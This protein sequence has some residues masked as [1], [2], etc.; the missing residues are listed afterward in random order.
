M[1][2]KNGN[3]RHV[4]ATALLFV[5]L[6]VGS[7]G[8][9]GCIPAVVIPGVVI[10]QWADELAD[11]LTQDIISSSSLYE[12]AVL[13]AQASDEAVAALGYPLVGGRVGTPS[14]YNF[15]APGYGHANISFRISGPKGTGRLHLVA[16]LRGGAAETW[17]RS[18]S[19]AVVVTIPDYRAAD[20]E[21][22]KLELT[23]DNSA[24]WIDLL[25]GAK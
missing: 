5:V 14:E 7:L 19:G 12:L 13:R 23:V 24:Q 22:E 16:E 21:F 3:A 17:V 11:D 25:G 4:H 20:W 8:L 1:S 9:T 10:G 18:E 2:H 6:V 15:E